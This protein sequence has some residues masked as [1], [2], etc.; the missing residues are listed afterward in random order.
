[1]KVDT[2]TSP[3][4]TMYPLTAMLYKYIRGD[5]TLLQIGRVYDK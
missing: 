3:E 5:G 4:L 2:N 1:M